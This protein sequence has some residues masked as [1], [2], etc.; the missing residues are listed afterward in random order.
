M[1][2]TLNLKLWGPDGQFQEFELTDRSEVVTTLVTWS[3]ELGCGP[4]DVDYQ[5]NNG[6]RIMGECNPYA[7][8][9]D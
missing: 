8:E 5:V 1:S 9:V 3:K 7:G 4:N 6:L 2:E